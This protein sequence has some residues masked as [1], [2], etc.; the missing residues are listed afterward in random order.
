MYQKVPGLSVWRCGRGMG[1]LPLSLF[2]VT[3]NNSSAS[4]GW[5]THRKVQGG[6][7]NETAEKLLVSHMWPPATYV[8]FL[9]FLSYV[10]FSAFGKSFGSTH[11][12]INKGSYPFIHSYDWIPKNNS[13]EGNN[14]M[15]K[16][17]HSNIWTRA[18]A[19]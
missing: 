8:L 11:Q 6:T 19:L 4:L 3:S 1:Y 12:E 17:V 2:Y 10:S 13:K 7:A 14:Y 18:T 15:H 9:M 16:A 5:A